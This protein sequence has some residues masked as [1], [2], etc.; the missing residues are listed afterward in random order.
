M[1]EHPP[2]TALIAVVGP[3]AT[4]KSDLGVQLALRL[5]GAIVN[6]DASQL[7]RGM[8]VGTAK[9]PV[10]YR[11]GI[12]HRQIDVLDVTEEANVAAYQRYSRADLAT[13]QAGGRRALI[14]GGSGLYLRAALDVLDIPPTDPAVRAR[15][16][17]ECATTGLAPLRARLQAADPVAAGTIEANNARRVIRALEVIELT[18][19]PFS[20]TMPRR[21][22][23]RP[24]V[25][26]GLD[27]DT[28][29]LDARIERRV[30]RMFQAGLIAEVEALV[31]RG[32]RRGRTASTAIGYAQVLALLDGRLT[33]SQ[34]REQTVQATRRLVRRQRSWFRADPRTHWLPAGDPLLVERALAVVGENG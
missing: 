16:E 33:E 24:T 15:L 19:R 6:A 4:G 29:T 26:I 17:Q 32:L 28:E 25:V 12:E 14:V 21:E 34:A 10:A 5:G 2:T 13:I 3:T 20:A 18:G 31:E 23:F 22:H 30:A 27:D 8:D 7:Y 9:L 1:S 11:H